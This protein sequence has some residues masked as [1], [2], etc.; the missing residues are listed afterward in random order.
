MEIPTMKL[1]PMAGADA[2]I[3]RNQAAENNAILK[4]NKAE[5]GK[6][7][8]KDDFLKILIVQLQ[9]QDP[10]SPM[11]DKEFIAQMAQFSSLEQMTNMS[12]NFTKLAST[13]GTGEALSTIGMEVSLAADEGV[14]T[15]I[16]TGVTRGADPL[17]RV[18]GK[19]YPFEQVD[20]VRAPLSYAAAAYESSSLTE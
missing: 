9:N 2:T 17:V 1:A 5:S 15:G 16:V 19:D 7:L 13:L 6:E 14:V 3:A 8:N 18:N 20:S 10:T 4:A 12:A 11:E